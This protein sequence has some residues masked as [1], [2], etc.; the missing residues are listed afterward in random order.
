MWARARARSP[1]LFPTG[2]RFEPGLTIAMTENAYMT[3]KAWV[4][5]TK[6]IVDGYRQIPLIPDNPQWWMLE[7]FDGFGSHTIKIEAME[8]RFFYTEVMLKFYYICPNYFFCSI[9]THRR[10]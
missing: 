5:I 1:P 7:C 9:N 8:V 4:G 2:Y 3:E 6:K 10:S